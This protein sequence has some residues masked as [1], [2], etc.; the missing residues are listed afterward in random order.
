MTLERFE[1][2]KKDFKKEMEKDKP[3]V[4]KKG[5]KKLTGK[6]LFTINPD[7]EGQLDDGDVGVSIYDMIDIKN[8]RD[9]PE[10]QDDQ[11]ANIEIDEDLFDADDLDGLDEELDDLKVNDE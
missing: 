10:Q 4:E 2:W 5:D 6:E 9:N 8:H 1:K 3:V 7:L 11:E